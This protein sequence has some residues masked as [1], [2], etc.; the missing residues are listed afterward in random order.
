MANVS[1]TLKGSGD[2]NTGADWSG[3]KAPGAGDAVTLSSASAQ[4]ITVSLAEHAAQITS[5]NDL[6]SISGGNLSVSGTVHLA[7][8]LEEDSGGT[9]TLGAGVDSLSGGVALT[10]GTIA[11]GAGTTL[12]LAGAASL[13]SAGNVNGAAFDGAGTLA[14]SGLVTI[15]EDGDAAEALLGGGMKWVNTGTVVQAGIVDAAYNG[16]IAFTV[17]NHA[18]AVF[19]FTTDVA[20]LMNMQ[21]DNGHGTLVTASSVFNNYGL[22]EKTGGFGQTTVYSTVYST[23]TIAVTSGSSGTMVLEDGGVVQGKVMGIGELMF[24][25]G[26]TLENVAVSIYDLDVAGGTVAVNNVVLSGTLS[27]ESQINQIGGMTLKSGGTLLVDG[28]YDIASNHSIHAGGGV[29]VIDAGGV[30]EKG[31]GGGTSG[32]NVGPSVQDNGTIAAQVGTLRVLGALSGSGGATIA[33]GAELIVGNVAAGLSMTLGAGSE[34]RLHSP[35]GFH[36]EIDGFVSGTTLDI[37]AVVTGATVGTAGTLVLKDN[38]AAVATLL[39][40]GSKVGE[41]FTLGTDGLG[42]TQLTIGAQQPKFLPGMTAPTAAAPAVVLLEAHHFAAAVGGT[43]ATAAVG[44]ADFGGEISLSGS[45]LPAGF[46]FSA[47][48]FHFG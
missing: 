45:H 38:G 2:W 25:G 43:A 37:G 26:G 11:F 23:G 34:L 48:G 7:G 10:T 22:M 18:G 9:L 19:D 4:T 17:N 41:V 31:A 15:E 1:W 13:G 27:D 24:T 6:L 40:S 8:G 35:S 47:H 21:V 42:G 3:G 12:N 32:A 44:G 36:G 30:L 28:V 20:C 5:T 16:G 33:S 46:T 39:V 14:S 29:I